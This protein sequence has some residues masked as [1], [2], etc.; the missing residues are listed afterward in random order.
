MYLGIIVLG[1]YCFFRENFV[2]EVIAKKLVPEGS[3]AY[4][5]GEADEFSHGI[6]L[7]LPPFYAHFEKDTFLYL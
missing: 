6:S 7:Q 5:L 4:F 1:F 3:N 2:F